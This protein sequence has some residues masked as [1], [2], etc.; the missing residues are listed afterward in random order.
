MIEQ[1]YTWVYT[2]KMLELLDEFSSVRIQNQHT[3]I[4]CVSLHEQ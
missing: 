4:S 2:P 3:K 1:S